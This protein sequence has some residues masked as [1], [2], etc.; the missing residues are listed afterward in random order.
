M[1]IGCHR[2]STLALPRPPA[3]RAVT[4][5]LFSLAPVQIVR[6][7][8]DPE[9]AELSTQSKAVHLLTGTSVAVGS[10]SWSATLAQC[11]L[12]DIAQHR[13][14]DGDQV[15]FRSDFNGIPRRTHYWAA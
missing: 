7:L 14:Q 10:S 1:H 4:R 11:T 5:T 15:D 12:L 13:C 3:L 6:S 2:A 8:V 9:R